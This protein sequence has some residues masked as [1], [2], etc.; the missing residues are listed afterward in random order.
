MPAQSKIPN[1][2]AFLNAVKLFAPWA[3]RR[4]TANLLLR[5]GEAYTQIRQK[6][7]S[8]FYRFGRR[9]MHPPINDFF[10]FVCVAL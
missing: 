9:E 6:N 3:Q 10:L 5:G 4:Q 7:Q 1:L 8:F 2:T